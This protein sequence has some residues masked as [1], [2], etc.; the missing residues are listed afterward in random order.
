MKKTEREKQVTKALGWEK[1][2]PLDLGVSVRAIKQTHAP[3]KVG[4]QI[5]DREITYL[6]LRL[7]TGAYVECRVEG[8]MSHEALIEALCIDPHYEA[9]KKANTVQKR[10]VHLETEMEAD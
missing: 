8:S 4:R 10:D 5:V 7:P 1:A 6:K 2:I 3:V 9:I